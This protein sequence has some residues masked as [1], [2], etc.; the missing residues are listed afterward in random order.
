MFYVQVNLCQKHGGCSDCRTALC[1]FLS[2]Q[3]F[4]NILGCFEAKST[5]GWSRLTPSINYD[6][7]LSMELRVQYMKT[8]SSE[9]VVY[10]PKLFFVLTFKTIYVQIQQ[11]SNRKLYAQIQPALPLLRPFTQ[12]LT[13]GH[14]NI[15]P[16]SS[17]S[18]LQG[19]TGLFLWTAQKNAKLE[20][21]ATDLQS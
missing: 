11:H 21:P 12:S 20:K 17:I 6:N 13:V 5:T 18:M 3:L 10:I 7:R 19:W 2:L 4:P 14:Q 15:R 9:D 16:Q 8:T 1:Q